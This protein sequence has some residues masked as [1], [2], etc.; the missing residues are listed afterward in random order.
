MNVDVS[1]CRE[2]EED[3]VTDGPSRV[4]LAGFQ[5]ID[6]KRH[7]ARRIHGLMFANS[8]RSVVVSDVR[9]SVPGGSSDVRNTIPDGPTQ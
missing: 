1:A 4:S 3:I 8:T 2:Q 5:G 7:L 6:H 9:N